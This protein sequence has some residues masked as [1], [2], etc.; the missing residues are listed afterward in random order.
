MDEH[1]V[2]L[3]SD[4]FIVE[5]ELPLAHLNGDPNSGGTKHKLVDW[6]KFRDKELGEIDDWSAK[7]L[8]ATEGATEEIES[9]EEIETIYPRLAHLLEARRSL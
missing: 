6:R 9:P 4:H 1:G 2:N 3:G 8:A 7:L 5:I